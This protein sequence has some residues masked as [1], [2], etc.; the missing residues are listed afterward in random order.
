MSGHSHFSTIKHKKATEDAKKGRMFSKISKM[1]SL[2]ACGGGGDPEKNIKLKQA[3]LEAKKAN[4]PKSNIERAIKSGMGE[5]EGKSFEEIRIESLGPERVNIIMEGITDNKNRTLLEI[6][7]ILQKY[8]GKIASEGAVAW[9]FEQKGIIATEKN[10]DEDLELKIIEA[11]AEDI[12]KR[13]QITEIITPP[14]E[15]NAM[16]EKLKRFLDIK[17]S[18][19]GWLPKSTIF[20]KRDREK[21][22]EL[23]LELED[24]ESINEVYTNID[25]EDIG[26]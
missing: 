5:I 21:I 20:V 1:L 7:Q 16:E 11:G 19:L 18:R 23:L 14:T 12:K 22:N 25:Y 6:K 8:G 26:S 4:M 15:L 24:S 9:Q 3:I 17:N 10:L 2:A 13:E